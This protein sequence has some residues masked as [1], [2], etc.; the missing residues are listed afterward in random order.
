MRG[1]LVIQRSHQTSKDLVTYLESKFC[2]KINSFILSPFGYERTS[3]RRITGRNSSPK[4]LTSAGTPAKKNLGQSAT[5]IT[6]TIQKLTARIT[7][8]L[9]NIMHIGHSSTD[10]NKPDAAF[11]G[12]RTACKV[13][14]ERV[15]HGLLFH[16]ADDDFECRSAFLF[17]E[18]V[19]EK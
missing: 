10:G 18:P 7:K 17:S 12:C 11:T 6:K 14:R 2:S 15:E 3:L 13:A 8:P 5:P 16:S 4:T 19:V 9:G 1:N